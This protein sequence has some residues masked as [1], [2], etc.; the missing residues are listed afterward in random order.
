MFLVEPDRVE[1]VRSN[2]KV[3]EL[4][5]KYVPTAVGASGSVV[6]IGGE[7]STFTSVWSFHSPSVVCNR[8]R[9]CICMTG[10]ERY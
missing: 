9:R 6:A 5:T 2:Q 8:T 7:V 1:A 10:M 3:H 4:K